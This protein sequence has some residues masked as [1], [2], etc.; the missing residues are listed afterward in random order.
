MPST[1]TITAF[2]TFTANTKARATQVNAN[3]DVFRGH[4]IPISPNTIT[5]ESLTW[6][7]GSA[8]YRWRSGY[9]RS[10]DLTSN[11]TTGNAIS[12]EGLTSGAS[13][14][15]LFKIGGTEYFRVQAATGNTAT[16]EIGQ[17]AVSTGYTL[18]ASGVTSSANMVGT[19]ITLNCSGKPV[20]IYAQALEG[21]INEIDITS[22]GNASLGSIGTQVTLFKD[23][24]TLSSWNFVLQLTGLTTSSKTISYPITS[25]RYTDINSTAGSHTYH[26]FYNV[27]GGVFVINNF[28][29]IAKENTF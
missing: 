16:A 23:G 3:F 14:A 24:G 13:G 22:F 15:I 28:R 21:V 1:A 5:A 12:I 25:I 20:E 17:Y 4:I 7:I 18:G 10:I 8:D 2:Y 6:D 26:L 27:N 11:T 29:L 19:T 9:F